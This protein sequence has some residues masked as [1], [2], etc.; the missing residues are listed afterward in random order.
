M[1]IGVA[2]SQMSA[3]MREGVAI[4]I[5]LG[6]VLFSAHIGGDPHNPSLGTAAATLWGCFLL[7]IVVWKPRLLRA[8]TWPLKN[9][10]L[11]FFIG[12][13]VKASGVLRAPPSMNPLKQPA[14]ASDE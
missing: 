5:L 10:F 12:K 4:L 9:F 2:V 8:I 11:G 13:G 1:M 3:F 14:P 6:G 7:S